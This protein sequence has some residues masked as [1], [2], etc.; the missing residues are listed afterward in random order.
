MSNLGIPGLAIGI[1]RGDQILHV[2]GYG[3]ADNAGRPMTAQTPFLVA[4]FS[5]S[6]TAVGV[7]QLVDE[8]KIDL[9]APVQSYLPWLQVAD[10][11]YSA[12]ITIRHLLN[13]TSGFSEVEGDKRNLEASFAEDALETSLRELKNQSLSFPR[14]QPS[15]IPTP[16]TTCWVC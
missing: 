7:M 11:E 1:V 14:A 3:V 8:G 13:Q 16:I 2:Q 6:I 9:D 10:A 15:N 4:S 5:K 12:Q